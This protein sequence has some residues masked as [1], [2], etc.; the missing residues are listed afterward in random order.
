M[1]LKDMATKIGKSALTFGALKLILMSGLIALPAGQIMAIL[2]VVR[3][4]CLFA[5]KYYQSYVPS[6]YS[7][8]ILILL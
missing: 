3:E 2:V 4:L 7:L 1:I 6:D 8:I 5:W